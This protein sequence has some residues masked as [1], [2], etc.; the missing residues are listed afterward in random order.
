[1]TL[2][3]N[4]KDAWR[5][6]SVQIA[7][8]IAAVNLAWETLPAD[9]LAVIPADWRGWINIGLAV[10]MLVVRLIDQSK[11]EASE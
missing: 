1:M 6:W 10:A 3:A 2:V 11:P 5:W 4:W 9:A 8:V 7:T